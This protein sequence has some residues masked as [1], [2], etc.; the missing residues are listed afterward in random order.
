MEADNYLKTRLQDQIDWYDKKSLTSQRLF[1]RLRIMEIVA[2]ALIPLVSG[3]SIS[4]PDFTT[5]G[6]I[7]VGILGVMV[8]IISGVLSL[9]RY[10]EHWV[11][12]RG[13]CESLKKEKILFEAQVEPYNTPDAFNL[14]VQRAETLIS[15]ENT[16][17]AQYM[18]VPQND[19]KGEKSASAPKP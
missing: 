3:F 19:K 13:T 8:S 2:A 12:Y 5:Y 10:Q 11:E 9:G 16:N 17:W 14:L 6:I 18:M 4:R 7:T 15:K 1:M